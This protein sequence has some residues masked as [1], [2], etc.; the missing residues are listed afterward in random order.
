MIVALLAGT[1]AFHDYMVRIS[2]Y[3]RIMRQAN[4]ALCNFH[5]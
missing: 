4:V 5:F 1:M 3:H 2:I